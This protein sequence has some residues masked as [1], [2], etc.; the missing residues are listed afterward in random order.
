[1]VSME[2]SDHSHSKGQKYKH[3]AKPSLIEVS[4]CPTRGHNPALGLGAAGG[5]GEQWWA[6]GSSL[7]APA[8]QMALHPRSGRQPKAPLL[9]PT[10]ELTL[11]KLYWVAGTNNFLQPGHEKKKF[12]NH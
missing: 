7:P 11:V 2:T 5:S 9:G 4:G 12:E 6:Q 1:M 10:P 8:P 3:A